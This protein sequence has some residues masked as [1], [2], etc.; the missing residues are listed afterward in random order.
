MFFSWKSGKSR[1]K[2][3]SRSA[4]PTWVC[5]FLV[6]LLKLVNLDLKDLQVC[7]YC[8][9][10]DKW[11]NFLGEPGVAGNPG[12]RGVDGTLSDAPG[13]AGIL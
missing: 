6:Y 13:V 11:R 9:N 4:R 5:F 10:L 12:Q 3:N 7:L 1:P 2:R 8:A